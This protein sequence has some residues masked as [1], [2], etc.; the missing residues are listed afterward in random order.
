MLNNKPTI[1]FS[2]YDDIK[3]PHY[4]GGGAIAVHEI[5]KRLR[6]TFD[7][8]VL[9][10]DYNGKKEER[11]DGILYERFGSA[12][13]SPKVGMFLYQLGLPFIAKQKA[14]DLWI[15]SFCPPFTT[16]L[17][18]LF[19]KK[20]VVG[21]VHMLAAEDMERKYKLPFHIVQ[22][23]GLRQY[24]HL[25]ATTTSIK[26][27]VHAI[28]KR[29]QITVISNG[30]TK[31]FHPTNAKEKYL[32]YLGRIEV[33][34][35][36]IDLLINAFKQ[37]AAKYPEYRLV[38]AG[39]GD[40]NEMEKMKQLISDSSLTNKILLKGKVSGKKKEELFRHAACVVIP[41]RFETFALV[42]LEAMAYGAPVACF[43]IDGLS[44]VPKN[45]ARKANA[46]DSNSL[47]K[48]ISIVVSQ[49]AV[50]DTLKKEGNRYAKQYT[51]DA[52][53]KNYETYLK[54]LL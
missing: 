46:F 50:S 4:G 23:Y 1:Y 29:S 9:S 3:N 11:I 8:H 2:T 34:Q 48:E 53:A 5:A 25:I 36:G 15:E 33:D 16:A 32:L 18:P 13:F 26:A 37:F 49:K 54:T 21:V 52:L 30:I 7:V 41:S 10:W 12:F 17:L 39:S 22:N 35:K 19:I 40:K 43:D 27:K 42:A 20:P 6:N 24:Q 28:T 51:W 38:I 47:A 45:A 14:F 31:V 44:W